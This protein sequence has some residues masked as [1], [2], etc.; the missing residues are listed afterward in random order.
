MIAVSSF[1]PFAKSPEVANNQARAF[2]SWLP[3]FNAIFYMGN[4][5]PRLASP[6]TIFVPAPNPPSVRLL[7]QLASLM[8][9]PS[10]VINADIFLLPRAATVLRTAMRR[11]QAA[12]SFRLEFDQ[13]MRKA[14]RVDN[15]LDLFVAHPSVWQ[16][17]WPEM[18][19]EFRIGQPA[20]DSWLNAWLR[21]EYRM[22]YTDLSNHRIVFHPRHTRTQTALAK[23]LKP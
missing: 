19:S 7:I 23:P 18:P 13:D 12:T 6:K 16:R 10:C 11:F 2:A 8:A 3:V 15:G 9:A 1:K 5:E 22:A 21:E 4:P 17:C 20:W 14:R